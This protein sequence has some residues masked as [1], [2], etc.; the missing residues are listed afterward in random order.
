MPID[1]DKM[2]L[3]PVIGKLG[4]AVTYAPSAGQVFP[5]TGIFDEAYREIDVPSGI[6]VTSTCPVLG[7]RF[8]DFPAYAPPQQNDELTV[9]R[10]GVTYVVREVRPDGHG[11]AKLMLNFVADP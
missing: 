3:G 9:I 5:I 11:G 2:V 4:E 6:N 7:I 10:T 8:A 1:W